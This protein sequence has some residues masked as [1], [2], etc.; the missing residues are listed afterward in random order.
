M[1]VQKKLKQDP[2][3]LLP[4]EEFIASTRG[5]ILSWAVTTLRFIVIVVELIVMVGFL[6][7]FWLDARSS[8]LDDDIVQKQAIIEASSDFEKEFKLIQKRIEIFSYFAN[9]EHKA[10]DLLSVITSYLPGEILLEDVKLGPSEVEIEGVSFS[11]QG[12]AQYISNLDS[13]GTFEEILLKEL[14]SNEENASLFDFVLKA[15]L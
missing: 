11:E 4:R 15:T 9:P 2:I 5:R 7:R 3:N 8:D 14:S 1:A 13:A 12:V 6:S 10:S